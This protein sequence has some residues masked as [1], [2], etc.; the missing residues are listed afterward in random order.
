M[1]DFLLSQLKNKPM[2]AHQKITK[3]KVFRGKKK[4]Q[5]SK[6]EIGHARVDTEDNVE[7]AANIESENTLAEA[8]NDTTENNTQETLHIRQQ[9][10]IQDMRE[11]VNITAADRAKLLAGLSGVV[12]IKEETSLKVPKPASVSVNATASVKPVGTKQVRF[13]NNADPGENV[14]ENENVG[15]E[16]VNAAGMDELVVENL[17]T[18]RQTTTVR[19]KRK[20]GKETTTIKKRRDRLAKMGTI[21]KHS[22][23]NANENSLLPLEAGVIELRGNIE[24]RFPKPDKQIKLPID[25]FYLNNRKKFMQSINNLFYNYRERLDS[26]AQDISC[27]KKK[28]DFRLMA[29]QQIIKDYMNVRTPYRGLLLYH[30]LGSGKSCA[31]INIAEGIKHDKRVVVMTPAS[32]RRNYVEELKFCGDKLYKKNQYWSFVSIIKKNGDLNTSLIQALST[33]LSI[34]TAFVR[35]HRGAWLMNGTKKRSNYSNLSAAEKQVLDAQLNEMIMSKYRFISYNGLRARHLE[36]LTDNYT[37]NMFDNK[38]VIIDEAHNL[39]SRIVNK[40]DYPNS[41][42]MRLYDMLMDA[43]NTRIILLTGTPV[44]NYPNELGILFNILRGYIKT[45]YIPVITTTDRRVNQSTIERALAPLKLVDYVKYNISSKTLEITRN[46]YGFKTVAQRDTNARN[47]DNFVGVKRSN[48]AR[49]SITDAEFQQQIL[50]K[51]KTAGIEAN[52]H[53][54]H[55]E[56][57]KALPDTLD[58]FNDKFINLANADMKN[59]NMFKRRILGLASYFKSAQEQLMPSFNEETDYHIVKI[60]MSDYQFGK[61]EE[62]RV[63]ERNLEKKGKKKKKRKKGGDELYKDSVSTYK[64]FSRAFCNFVFPPNIPRPMPTTG[65]DIGTAI[66]H[67]LDIAVLDA[68]PITARVS[69]DGSQYTVDDTEQLARASDAMKDTTYEERIMTAMRELRSG[70]AEFLSPE[71][72]QTYSPKFAH[73]LNNIQ[74]AEHPGSH[75]LYSQFRTIE[76]IGVMKLV[77]EAN[78]FAQFKIRNVNDT[79]QLDISEEDRHKPM[80]VLYTGTETPEEKEIYRNVF[81]STWQ[82]IPTN[83]VEE[84]REMGENNHMGEIIKLMMITASG[85]EGITFLNVR[86]VHI[87][88]PYWHNVRTEQVIG[89]ARRICSHKDLPQELR[90]VEV[91]MYLMELTEDQLAGDTSI[92]LKK[93]DV[94]KIDGKTPVTTDET[95]YEISTMK[96]EIS[97]QLLQAVK[98]SSMDCAIH[99]RSDGGEEMACYSFGTVSSNAAAYKPAIENEESDTVSRVNIKK[100]QWKGEELRI[101]GKTYIQKKGSKEIYSYDSYIQALRDPNVTPMFLGYLVKVS[102]K[103]R[104]ISAEKYKK[105][106]TLRKKQNDKQQRQREWKK[107]TN[108]S[109]RPTATEQTATEQTGGNSGDGISNNNEITN[110]VESVSEKVNEANETNSTYKNN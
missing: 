88:E 11:R 38:V 20:P 72:L 17:N 13:A 18:P 63:D 49:Y 48:D 23:Y 64:I 7:A 99:T 97:K 10:V 37:V 40:L 44:I 32:L 62:A 100:I 58:D 8:V 75:L 21:S 101:G 78:G 70:S 53:G 55:V 31:S 61:Y 16:S 74:A 77:L 102:G 82:Y 14:A 103:Y 50:Q 92:E 105:L 93:N 84:L 56:K 35:K 54:I 71:G 86:Y 104:V 91:F 45:W 108:T 76:G 96:A 109:A 87:T 60:P 89:R 42:S 68:Q 27:D 28:G 9:P 46:P 12:G 67:A 80:F 66:E 73:I 41:L 81:N 3:I 43:Q 29:H 57:H 110:I 47:P 83:L 69:E 39:V 59:V 90:T 5:Q 107:R 98:E 79:W 94:S 30:G 6:R 15:A 1:A 95:L 22:L 52:I 2:P 26:E 33:A 51:L 24:R 85:A 19:T 4:R 65:S 36:E 34:T 106:T 25:A